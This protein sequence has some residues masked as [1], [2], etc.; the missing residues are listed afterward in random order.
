MVVGMSL[1]NGNKFKNLGQAC[2]I[3]AQIGFTTIAILSYAITFPW[4][5]LAVAIIMA[6]ST[7]FMECIG[8]YV[9]ITLKNSHEISENYRQQLENSTRSN[10]FLFCIVPINIMAC[11]S[12][13]CSSYTTFFVLFSQASTLIAP[14][15]ILALGIIFAAAT[16]ISMLIFNIKVSRDIWN[17]IRLKDTQSLNTIPNDNSNV[18]LTRQAECCSLLNTEKKVPS[19]SPNVSLINSTLFHNKSRLAHPPQNE[20]DQSEPTTITLMM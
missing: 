15:G 17:I 4:L 20:K 12:L 6:T 7:L 10:I 14:S 13:S 11:V 18:S 8:Y 1:L 16:V 3:I 19:D 5:P 2:F 9:T